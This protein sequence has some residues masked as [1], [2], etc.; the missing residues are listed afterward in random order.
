MKKRSIGFAFGL[1]HF[2]VLVILLGAIIFETWIIYPNIFHD[3]PRSFE[4]GMDFMTVNGPHD[5]FPPLGLLSLVLGVGSLLFNWRIKSIRYLI[6]GSILILFVCNLLLSMAYLW[7]RNTIMF[8]E[9]AAVHPV[10]FLQQTALE[11]QRAHK[12]RV[13]GVA[14]TSVMAF[15]AFLRMYRHGHTTKTTP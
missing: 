1:L 11:F 3:I 4:V 14:A 12:F 10:S 7:P 15:L 13:L 8:I 6:L 2:W 9:G 5:F